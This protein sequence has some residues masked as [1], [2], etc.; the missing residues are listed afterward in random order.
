MGWEIIFWAMFFSIWFY[1]ERNV[2]N[3]VVE[4]SNWFYLFIAL[5]PFYLIFFWNLFWK[6]KALKRFADLNLMSGLIVPGSTL[7]SFLKTFFIRN[8][9]VFIIISL[10]NPQ[11][12]KGKREAVSEGIE[13]MVALD[14]SKSM[15]AKDIHP[16][17]DRLN[18]AKLA[19]EK[20][21]DQLHGDRI[22]IVVFAGDAFNYV[23][24]T[25]DYRAVK[26][27]MNNLSTEMVQH[28]GTNIGWA[29]R[30]CLESFDFE[31]EMNKSIV[32]ISDGENHDQSAMDAVSI[33]QEKGVIINTVGMGLPK[34]AP[35]PEYKDGKQ[36]GLK[37][38]RDGNTILTK[39]NEPMLMELAQSGDGIYVP[40]KNLSIDLSQL[41]KRVNEIEKTEFEVTK[42][43]EYEDQFFA[44]L[45]FGWLFFVFY[46][47]LTER[48]SSV[49]EKWKV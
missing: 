23:P 46:L 42:Y 19:I 20:L 17:R 13:I 32:I 30:K 38:D 25:N 1:M 47:L 21:L 24:I 12:G 34:G 11:F 45:T 49:L 16:K 39:L 2:E 9:L 33:A 22:G 28:Q 5:I 27:Y 14:V 26:M 40:G 43:D 3:F 7:K 18:V 15:L 29:I 4:E 36:V 44:F 37:K 6:N 31:N 35:I 10:A 48:K 8:A 41:I